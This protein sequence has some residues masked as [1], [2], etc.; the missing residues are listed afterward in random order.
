MA[1]ARRRSSR[2][3][4]ARTVAI[5]GGGA[6]GALAAIQ[7]L[8]RASGSLKIVIVEPRAALGRGIAY[9]TDFDSHLLNVRAGDMS[10]LPDYPDHF[11]RWIRANVAKD[12]DRHSFARRS[13]YG[14]YASA[15]L[16][17]SL[18]DA[19]PQVSLDHYRSRATRVGVGGSRARVS[20]ENG[21]RISADRV[22]LA[23]GHPSPEN[24]LPAN[25]GIE[26]VSA[27]SGSA[28]EALEPDASVLLVGSGLTAVDAV[29]ALDERGHRGAI[30]VVSR[31]GKLPRV[32]GA[33]AEPV[34]SSWPD[35]AATARS[36]LRA[37]RETIRSTGSW[38]AAIDGLRPRT[39][40][41]WARASQ[42]ERRRF[43]RHLRFYWDIHRHRMPP[44]VASKI[45]T[46][47]W[48]KQLLIHAGRIVEASIEKDSNL[49]IRISLRGGRD[50]ISLSVARIINCTGP[51]S[52]LRGSSNPLIGNLL[53]SGIVQND[54]LAP[55]LLTDKDGALVGH[56]GAAS[57]VIFTLGPLRRGTLFETT[58]IPEI[59]Q[60]A[61]DLA[62]RLLTELH[63]TSL[64]R[65]DSYRPE[66][67]AFAG[68]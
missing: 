50:E 56:D 65:G 19:G 32:H 6:S 40:S 13:L 42:S 36:V 23:L 18:F 64:R 29:L 68:D 5:I 45:D 67:L 27:W 4:P 10:A 54:P 62:E 43:L 1:S 53:E 22:I 20:M 47:R 9:S 55:G 39:N 37:I 58:A 14:D 11:L 34:P 33:P 48:G 21:E 26:P 7:L 30:H 52:T 12:F 24:P 3:S 66:L 59:R 44:E 41:I 60:Q 2:R 63:C 15:T 25:T 16:A 38:Q 31:H 17:E 57:K 8:R 46:M 35:A 49:R 51:S 61:A 28:F